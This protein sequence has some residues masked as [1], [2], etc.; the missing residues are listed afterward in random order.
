MK[1]FKWI[2]LLFL[3][4]ISLSSCVSIK[5]NQMDFLNKIDLAF[6]QK[7]IEKGNQSNPIIEFHILFKEPISPK[8]LLK[9]IHFRNQEAVV[10]FVN[11]KE[12]S[13]HFSQHLATQDLILDK[14]STKEYGN[15]APIVTNPQLVLNPNEAVLE[16]KLKNKTYFFKF[17][18]MQE[19]Q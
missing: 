16:Y 1:D 10:V 4:V 2:I 15:V 11:N 12:Y 18:N 6:S 19:R 9:K 3:V 14:D 7:H 5:K 8:I 13:A 17:I